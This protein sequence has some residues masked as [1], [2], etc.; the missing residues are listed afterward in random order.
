MGRS[1]G[2]VVLSEKGVEAARKVIA[3]SKKDEFYQGLASSSSS[4]NWSIDAGWRFDI[5]GG[6]NTG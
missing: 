3:R 6:S 4:Q 2:F 5:G 1:I